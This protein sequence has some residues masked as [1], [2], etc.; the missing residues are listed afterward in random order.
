MIEEHKSYN[1]IFHHPRPV[2]NEGTSASQ[3][4]P[5]LMYKALQEIGYQV[6]LVAGFAAERNEDI[7]TIK[8]KILDG[9]KYD[10]LY[11]ESST[12][13][14]LLTEPHRLPTHPVLDFRF[15]AWLRKRYIPIGLFYRDIYW[16]FDY[17]RENQPLY[18]TAITIPC[19]KYD[20]YQYKK[21]LDHLF[22]PAFGYKKAFPS[23]WPGERLSVLPPGCNPDGINIGNS[24]IKMHENLK[25][26]YVGG[27]LPPLYNIKPL[28]ETISELDGIILTVCC[29]KYEWVKVRDQYEPFD[30]SKISIIHAHGEELDSLYSSA[31][32]FAIIRKPHPYLNFAT[33]FKVFEALGYGIPIVTTNGTETARFVEREQIGWIT[34]NCDDLRRILT[35][36]KQNPQEVSKMRKH[37]ESVR[38]NHTW[39]SRA[40]KV[41]DTLS[42][43]NSEK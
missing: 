18:K 39:S 32:L 30:K 3:I 34:S 13:P 22:I 7:Q 10:F 28:L 17:Y 31:D 1:A 26:F 38:F 4:R 19:Y 43:I 33:P 41:A 16:R 27:I 5:Y 20:W 21:T 15:F 14:T 25:I 23:E 35:Y 40:Q 12:W 9:C 36:L 11:S 6:D 24:N 37:V 8:T 29:R 2:N 42:G